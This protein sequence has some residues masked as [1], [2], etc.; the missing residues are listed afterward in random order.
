MGRHPAHWALYTFFVAKVG[1]RNEMIV[2][3]KNDITAFAAIPAIWPTGRNIFF[4]AEGN[5][6]VAPVTRF[7]P[8][9]CNIYK[10]FAHPSWLSA[11]VFLQ[12][13]QN[14]P[15]SPAYYT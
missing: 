2:H 6:A 15:D 13:K 14:S 1:K 3:L 7:Y 9:L 11:F 4:T 10:H 5:S 8:D 12:R